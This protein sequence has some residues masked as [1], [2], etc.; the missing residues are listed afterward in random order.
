MFGPF[1][2]GGRA[3]VFGGLGVGK[4]VVLKEFIHNAIQQFQ[5]V[6][7]FTGIG[8]RSSEGLELWDEIKRRGVLDQT[9]MV[10]GQMKEP[11]EA[12]FMIGAL[13]GVLS[14]A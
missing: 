7:V 8:E 3:A 10:F 1:T 9:A 4:T 12:R 6:T 14:D 13:D 2:H 11:P 5:G